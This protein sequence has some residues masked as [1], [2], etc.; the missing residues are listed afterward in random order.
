MVASKEELLAMIEGKLDSSE[1]EHQ[2]VQVVVT[3]KGESEQAVLQLVRA[4][5]SLY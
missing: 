2:N 3:V 1:H 4:E 5:G